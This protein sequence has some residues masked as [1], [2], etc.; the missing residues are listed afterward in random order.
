MKIENSTPSGI[1]R[2]FITAKV[3]YL[4]QALPLFHIQKPMPVGSIAR[5]KIDKICAIESFK[6]ENSTFAIVKGKTSKTAP[7]YALAIKFVSVFPM[8]FFQ[9]TCPR[10]KA[11]LEPSI[12]RMP[13]TIIS[14]E[15]FCHK[16]TIAPIT[17]NKIQKI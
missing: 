12:K 15:M 9:R 3:E 7:K 5:Y 2:L 6:N 1:F 13:F 14:K 4:T 8:Y 11:Q 17:D 16:I 10:A